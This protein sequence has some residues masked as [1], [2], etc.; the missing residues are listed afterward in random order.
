MSSLVDPLVAPLDHARVLGIRA[1]GPIGRTLVARRELRVGVNGALSVAMALALTLVAPTWLLAFSPL[2]MGVPHLLADV[3]YLVVRPGLHRRWSLWA[4]IG[5]PLAVLA[6]TGD[7]RYGLVAIP[8]TA[9]VALGSRLSRCAGALV[10]VGVVAAAVVAGRFATSMLLAHGHNLVAIAIFLLWRRRRTGWHWLPVVAFSLGYLALL[11]G[12]VTP[13]R[14]VG[15]PSGQ[16]MAFH[17]GWYARGVAEPWA[18]RWVLSFAFAQAVH[19]G[20]WIRVVPDEDQR[21]DTTRTVRR[22]LADLVADL[23]WPAVLGVAAVA[24]GFLGWGVV[25][26]LAARTRYLDLALTHGYLELA[27]LTLWAVERRVGRATARSP[28]G[29]TGQTPGSLER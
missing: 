15:D 28:R 21:R 29:S 10:G 16:S 19:Y 6:W 2:V 9:A 7:S 14:G 25:A 4:A 1:L 18:T 24:V 26:P 23:G 5:G 8:A 3:R 20:L 27:V 22:T 11:A 12:W 13:W 17:V